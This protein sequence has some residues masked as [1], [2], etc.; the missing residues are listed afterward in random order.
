MLCFVHLLSKRE[1]A[2]CHSFTKTFMKFRSIK[3]GNCS[4]LP[5]GLAAAYMPF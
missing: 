3:L 5:V 2:S 1:F 4:Q